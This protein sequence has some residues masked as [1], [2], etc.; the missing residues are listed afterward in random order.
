MTINFDLLKFYP[1]INATDPA[2]SGYG[3]DADTTATM[4]TGVANNEF[5]DISNSER[6]S[7]KIDYRK[8][9]IRNENADEWE[10]VVLYV[11]QNTPSEDDTIDICQA[12]TLSCLGTSVLIG[13]ADFESDTIITF[14]TPATFAVRPGEKV[15][16]YTSDPDMG[17]PQTVATIVGNSIHLASPF[18]GATGS[19]HDIYVC[20]A[21][22]F[23]YSAP[24]SLSGGMW[25]G[26]IPGNAHI[27]VWKR[28][29]SDAG[30]A[31]YTNN[32]VII[33]WEST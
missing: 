13:T 5:D 24:A 30:A 15:F 26:S 19:A 23:D 7:G 21:T 18:S 31:G 2:S 11:A 28:R 32:S 17:D 4:T 14:A 10:Q 22:M 33:R 1:P 12:G 9:F 29:T 8:Q 25:V 27:G 3:G 20:P 6:I 16:D